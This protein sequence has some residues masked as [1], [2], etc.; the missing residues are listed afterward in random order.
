MSTEELKEK[1]RE[2]TSLIQAAQDT[3]DKVENELFYR[4]HPEC[5]IVSSGD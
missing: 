3:L 4:K 1:E 5:R 2:L